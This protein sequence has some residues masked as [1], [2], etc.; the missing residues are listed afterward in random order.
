M[1]KSVAMIYLILM[2]VFLMQ[3]IGAMAAPTAPAM[4]F[5]CTMSENVQINESYLEKLGQEIQTETLDQTL[6]QNRDLM[7]NIMRKVL[8]FHRI[9]GGLVVFEYLQ[10]V[11]MKGS[12]NPALQQLKPEERKTIEQALRSLRRPMED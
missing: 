10:E 5:Q 7:A 11:S 4:D 12:F 9:Q 3:G 2:M 8:C 1:E 6:N